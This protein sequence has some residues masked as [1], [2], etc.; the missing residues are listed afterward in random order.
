MIDENDLKIVKKAVK[1]VI[2]E[3]FLPII[4]ESFSSSQKENTVLFS[5]LRNDIRE[6]VAILDKRIDNLCSHVDDFMH[7]HQKLDQELTMMR[8]R[9]ERME[10]QMQQLQARFT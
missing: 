4:H 9:I 7:L 3:N 8:A 10:E 2:E 6:G 1:E 5:E